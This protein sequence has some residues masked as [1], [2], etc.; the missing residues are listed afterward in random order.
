MAGELQ[1]ISAAGAN[2][3][4]LLYI[5]SGVNAG[6][7]AYECCC[8]CEHCDSYPSQFSVVISG[9]VLCTDCYD[10]PEY[11]SR[12]V[13][14]DS[15]SRSFVMTLYDATIWCTW[16]NLDVGSWVSTI[17]PTDD[18]S[19]AGTNSTRSAMASLQK[20]SETQWRFIIHAAGVPVFFG[21]ATVASGDCTSGIVIDNDLL[22]CEGLPRGI[23]GTATITAI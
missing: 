17:Y 15:V 11:G 19:G 18:C 23:E 3:G 22:S 16:A 14:D 20:I 5:E 21:E 9:L 2:Q 13:T 8:K 7:L 4:K 1:Y 6:K 12:K 10:I